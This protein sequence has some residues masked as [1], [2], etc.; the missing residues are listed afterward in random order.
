MNGSIQNHINSFNSKDNVNQLNGVEIQLQHRFENGC[1]T[2]NH[3]FYLNGV[4][5][6][7]TYNRL[8]IDVHTSIS[9]HFIE[10]L[11]QIHTN[12]FYAYK[13]EIE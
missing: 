10:W 4:A 7:N 5:W 12:E 9:W 2:T 13:M 11:F 1:P 6:K 8:T 3:K